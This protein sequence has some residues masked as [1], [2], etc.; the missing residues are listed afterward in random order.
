MKPSSM[1]QGFQSGTFPRGKTKLCPL[2]EENDPKILGEEYD[3]QLDD[4]CAQIQQ[5]P[6]IPTTKCLATLPQ[7]VCTPDVI[8]EEIIE[9]YPGSE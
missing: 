6:Q 9:D 4:S 2:V 5:M 7:T 8:I 3:V 1:E